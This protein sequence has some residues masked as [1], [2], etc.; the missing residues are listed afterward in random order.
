MIKKEVKVAAE[1]GKSRRGKNI[2]GVRMEKGGR[3][4]VWGV[5]E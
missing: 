5:D 4:S 1:A 2:G 3:I